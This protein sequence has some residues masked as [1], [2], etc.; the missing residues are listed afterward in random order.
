MIMIISILTIIIKV[1]LLNSSYPNAKN[2]IHNSI[3]DG[4]DAVFFY[5][6]EQFEHENLITMHESG[7]F[8]F[9]YTQPPPKIVQVYMASDEETR[10]GIGVNFTNSI[11]KNTLTHNLKTGFDNIEHLLQDETILSLS[12]QCDAV[13][14]HKNENGFDTESDAKSRKF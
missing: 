14:F 10:L 5:C 3:G 13:C 9:G 8:S 4:A 1:I 6:R 7:I 2:L 12:K 11:I